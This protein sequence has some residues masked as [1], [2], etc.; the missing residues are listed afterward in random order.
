MGY[1]WREHVDKEASAGSLCH[2]MIENDI[3]GR[4]QPEEGLVVCEDQASVEKAK[5]GFQAYLRWKGQTNLQ[6]VETEVNLVSEKHQFGGC[7]D[8]VGTSDGV[9]VLPDWKCANGTY[10][11]VVLQVAAYRALWNENNPDRPIERCMCLR[12]GKQEADFHYHDWT[13]DTM[14]WAFDIFL[15]QF[16]LYQAEKRLKRLAS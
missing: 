11:G 15:K 13:A 3:L 7:P 6:L 16:E 8:A 2:Q 12:V 5:Q 10:P 1:G 14:D 4:P 9:Y